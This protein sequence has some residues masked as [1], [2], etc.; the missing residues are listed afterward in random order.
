MNQAVTE[1]AILHDLQY[2]LPEDRIVLETVWSHGGLTNK[3]ELYEVQARRG[4]FKGVRS[5]AACLTR[6]AERGLITYDTKQY[7]SM[8]GE[9]VTHRHY[10]TLNEEAVLEEASETAMQYSLFL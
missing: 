9:R 6:L 8:E 10:I 3:W 5:M 1:L 7:A 2:T 4:G